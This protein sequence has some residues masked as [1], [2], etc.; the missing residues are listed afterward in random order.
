MEQDFQDLQD[1]QDFFVAECA[2]SGDPALQRGVVR[3]R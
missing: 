3:R 2:G 1:S